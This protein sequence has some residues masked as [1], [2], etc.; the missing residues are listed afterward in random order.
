MLI[1]GL[2]S[3]FEKIPKNTKIQLCSFLKT[4][5]GLFRFLLVVHYQLQIIF[6]FIF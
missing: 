4:E 5:K 1:S 3:R 2:E 6:N